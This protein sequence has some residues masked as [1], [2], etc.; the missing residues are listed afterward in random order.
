L[1]F[2]FVKQRCYLRFCRKKKIFTFRGGGGEGE[3][4]P[5]FGGFGGGIRGA[6]AS[7]EGNFLPT[8]AVGSS[9]LSGVPIGGKG[10]L[11][12]GGFQPGGNFFPPGPSAGPN[13]FILFFGRGGDG[14]LTI[15]GAGIC[16]PRCG[17]FSRREP[18]E[19]F[20]PRGAEATNR[21][22]ILNFQKKA[23]IP[24]RGLTTATW[25]ARF[26]SNK[27]GRETKKRVDFPAEKRGFKCFLW[28]AGGKKKK[29]K[30]N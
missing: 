28:G 25:G 21:V 10:Q 8:F 29:K 17:T 4:G 12:P 13:A 30:K 20:H 3:V 7:G 6:F 16:W 22:Q 27:R 11:F 14:R 2:F 26:C 18:R 15:L 5:I 19:V 1:W 9:G 23:A 24:G